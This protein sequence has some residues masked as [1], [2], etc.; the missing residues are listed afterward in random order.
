MPRGKEG[1]SE[2]SIPGGEGGALLKECTVDAPIAVRRHCHLVAALHY[3][4]AL[5]RQTGLLPLD[6]T[7]NGIWHSRFWA[8]HEL[9]V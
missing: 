9:G 6:Y 8:E 1:P 2:L 3:D 4:F 5:L 7:P